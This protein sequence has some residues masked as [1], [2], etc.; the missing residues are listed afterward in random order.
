MKNKKICYLILTLIIIVFHKNIYLYIQKIN[1]YFMKQIVFSLKKQKIFYYLIFVFCYGLIHTFSPGHGKTYIFKLSLKN[2][3]SKLIIISAIIAY[4]QGVIS[5]FI[6][7]FFIKSISQLQFLDIAT[8]N[9]Y[10]ITLILLSLFNLFLENKT[11]LIHNFHFIIGIFFPCSGVL[12]VLLL[13][14]TLNKNISFF[15]LMLFM[16]T[17][18]FIALSSFSVIVKNI[19]LSLNLKEKYIKIFN[20]I[21]NIFILIIGIYIIKL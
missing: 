4:V 21:I 7:I 17:G 5:Y 13:G 6:A 15:S 1:L 20:L 3:L 12:S 10:G 19:N 16:S 14:H 8:K 9:I 11:K 2:K 18:I